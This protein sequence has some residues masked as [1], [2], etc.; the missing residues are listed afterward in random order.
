MSSFQFDI[1]CNA[2]RG[3]SLFLL[4]SSRAHAFLTQ[5]LNSFLGVLHSLFGFGGLGFTLSDASVPLGL[6]SQATG[7]VV[8]LVVH[9]NLG[10]LELV[11]GRLHFYG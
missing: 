1:G 3:N 5:L 4:D 11:L 2:I 7:F 6:F 9:G 8:V 10:L